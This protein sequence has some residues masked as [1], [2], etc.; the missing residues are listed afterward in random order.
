[1]RESTGWRRIIVRLRRLWVLPIRASRATRT[2]CR[3]PCVRCGRRGLSR[4]WCHVR[5]I[6]SRRVSLQSIRF[7]FS[8]RAAI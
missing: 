2:G 3:K 6:S 1:M 7:I 4:P 5:T 8:T